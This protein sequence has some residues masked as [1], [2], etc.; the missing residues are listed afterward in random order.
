MALPGAILD[1]QPVPYLELCLAKARARPEP[2]RLP[3]LPR[4][5]VQATLQELRVL[6]P[7]LQAEHQ[8]LE[9]PEVV[10]LQLTAAVDA[11]QALQEL[12][13]DAPLPHESHELTKKAEQEENDESN[14]IE[15]I[16]QEPH[17][18]RDQFSNVEA[19]VQDCQRDDV[20][21]RLLEEEQASRVPAVEEEAMNHEGQVFDERDQSLTLNNLPVVVPNKI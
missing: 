3:R 10:H 7:R 1:Q 5:Q 11:V 9:G 14:V 8:P 16:H 17:R 15:K 20:E 6:V 12:S 4:L 19:D 2:P 18:I 13:L 21:K